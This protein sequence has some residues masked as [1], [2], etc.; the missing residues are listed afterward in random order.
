MIEIKRLRQGPSLVIEDAAQFAFAFF[1]N[2]ASSAPGGY[3]DHA[4]LGEP[5]QVT[6]DDIVAINTTM[7]ARSPHAIWEPLTTAAGPQPWLVALELC[8]TS[9]NWMTRRGRSALDLQ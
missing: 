8:G 2:D 5:W 3:D 1:N 7:R 4:G 9:L 6:V